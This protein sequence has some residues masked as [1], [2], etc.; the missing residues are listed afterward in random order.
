MGVL[1]LVLSEASSPKVQTSAADHVPAAPRF[2]IW[3][4]APSLT[5]PLHNSLY[6]IC[7][8]DLHMRRVCPASYLSPEHSDGGA[9]RVCVP[10]QLNPAPGSLFRRLPLLFTVALGMVATVT[11]VSYRWDTKAR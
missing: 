10:L 4:S 11:A 7:A 1:K 3:S 8:E 2:C 6:K 5:A 9:A